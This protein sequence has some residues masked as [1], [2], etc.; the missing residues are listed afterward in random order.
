MTTPKGTCLCGKEKATIKIKEIMKWKLIGRGKQN[1]VRK[2]YAQ[3]Y[4]M[5]TSNCDENNIQ[6][7]GNEFE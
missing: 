4:D 1:K 7:I 5:K 2:L 6:D 3:K